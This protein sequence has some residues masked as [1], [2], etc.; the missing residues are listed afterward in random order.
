M[1]TKKN[2][3]TKKYFK[4]LVIYKTDFNFYFTIHIEMLLTE[5]LTPINLAE[6]KQV[7]C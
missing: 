6:F 5:K 4:V 3:V 1:G 7:L 2:L